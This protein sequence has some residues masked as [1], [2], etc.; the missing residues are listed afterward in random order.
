LVKAKYQDN[1]E[2]LQWMKKFFEINYN[3]EPY[4]ALAKRKGQDLFY[5]MGGDKVAKPSVGAAQ[6]SNPPAKTFVPKSSQPKSSLT[7][8][9]SAASSKATGGGGVVSSKKPVG[10]SDSEQVKHLTADLQEMK[11]NNSTLEKERD[12]YFGKLRDIELFLQAN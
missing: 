10:G 1:L 5:I 4:D 6:K 2:F 3:G 7:S 8:G 12:F 11:L 9:S